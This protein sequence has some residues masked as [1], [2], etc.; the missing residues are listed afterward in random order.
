MTEQAYHELL[1]LAREQTLLASCL[2]LLGWD[3]E[4]YMPRGG[5]AHRAD[6][7]ALLAG[8]HHQRATA[9][10]CGDVLRG[11]EGGGP[12]ADPDAPEAANVREL[13]RGYDRLTRLPRALVEE[14]A[15]TTTLAQQA[16]ADAR[17]AADFA[18]FRPWL[19]RV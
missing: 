15:R 17:R 4:T 18:R 12:R 3:E 14:L 11:G 19:E 9:R 13:R 2:E 8:L 6:Q 1:R 5:A 16:W 7:L 10:R